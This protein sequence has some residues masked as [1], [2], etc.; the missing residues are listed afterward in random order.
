M[1]IIKLAPV[2]PEGDNLQR[3]LIA[4][5]GMLFICN[6][7]TNFRYILYHNLLERRKYSLLYLLPGIPSCVVIVRDFI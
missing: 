2:P 3:G 4:I 1:K 6:N 7:N 5:E